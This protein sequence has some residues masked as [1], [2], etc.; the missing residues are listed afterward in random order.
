MRLLMSSSPALRGGLS[1][2]YIV[3]KNTDRWH[4]CRHPLHCGEVSLIEWNVCDWEE[5]AWASSSP[6][7]R[8]GLSDMQE[9]PVFIAA[10]IL[11]RHPLHCGEVS[12]IHDTV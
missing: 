5:G 10:Q 12:L 7:L 8:G 9:Q 4:E 6:A 2:P 11:G 3:Y 1:D